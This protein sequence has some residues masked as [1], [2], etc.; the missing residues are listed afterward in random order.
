MKQS[1]SVTRINVN[2]GEEEEEEGSSVDLETKQSANAPVK[3]VI[4]F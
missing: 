3:C 1:D 4:I 2:E